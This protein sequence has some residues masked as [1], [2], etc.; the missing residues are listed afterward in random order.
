MR[1]HLV[2]ANELSIQEMSVDQV[3]VTR[4]TPSSF[5]HEIFT[6]CV[7]LTN[8]KIIHSCNVYKK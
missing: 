3:A 2:D 8:E 4:P 7:L 1:P 5:Y 6:L